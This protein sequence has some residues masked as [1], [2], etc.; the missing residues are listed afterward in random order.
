MEQIAF[1]VDGLYIVLHGPFPSSVIDAAD[2][3]IQFS[4][5]R[6]LTGWLYIEWPTWRKNIV[7]IEALQARFDDLKLR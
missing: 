6:A 7:R 1:N 2:K 3:M 4:S 5:R